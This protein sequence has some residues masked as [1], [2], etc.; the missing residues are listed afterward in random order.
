M[1]NRILLI[2]DDPDFLLLLKYELTASGYTLITATNGRDGLEKAQ[3]EKPDLILT[4]L[5]LP[6]LN[7]YEICT[8]LKQDARYQKIPIFIL[9]ATKVLE[10][11]EQLAKECGA[12]AFILKTIDPKELLRKI[13]NTLSVLPPAA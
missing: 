8:M 3:Q 1:P 12:D 6:K 2:E 13:Q 11:D 9:S 7:G 5:M 10:K 4:D